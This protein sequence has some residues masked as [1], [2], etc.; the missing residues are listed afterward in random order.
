MLRAARR[1]DGFL[2]LPSVGFLGNCSIDPESACASTVAVATF[3]PGLYKIA[4]REVLSEL[5]RKQW[6]NIS[7][8]G[9]LD[10]AVTAALAGSVTDRTEGPELRAKQKDL[11]TEVQRVIANK[12]TDKQC[13]ALTAQGVHGMPIEEVARWL[14]TNRN[15]PPY[16][17]VRRARG[18]EISLGTRWT[19]G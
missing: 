17:G 3:S 8:D 12:L 5:R 7:L 13:T 14:S 18:V 9:L 4:A 1:H 19:F 11:L 6:A 10:S 15:A 2:P 16:T